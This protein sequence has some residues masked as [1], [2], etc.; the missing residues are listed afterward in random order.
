MNWAHVH[1]AINHVP[2]IGIIFGFLLLFY[3]MMKKNEEL[4]R[5]SLVIF[6]IIALIAI[7]V[8]FTGGGA[9]EVVEHLPGVSESI[10]ERHEESA[11]STFVMVEVLGLLTLGG[12]YLYRTP[13]KPSSWFVAL[14]LVLSIL[15]GGLMARTANLGGQIR[16]TE[17]RSESKPST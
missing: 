8:Y 12:L 7:P 14:S 16:H 1:I 11:F 6:V 3:G 10:I 9:E 17:I 15:V 2:V 5:T 13:K 4:K